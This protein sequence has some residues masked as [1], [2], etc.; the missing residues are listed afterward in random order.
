MMA[1][2]YDY[3]YGGS[4]HPETPPVM[5]NFAPVCN[6][7]PQAQSPASL[8]TTDIQGEEYAAR[9]ASRADE[10][11]AIAAEHAADEKRRQHNQDV[12][13]D[14]KLRIAAREDDDTR[15]KNSRARD[16]K[17]CLTR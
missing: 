13:N 2:G 8:P 11:A 1:R 16:D 17:Q 14:R 10:V 3:G 7:I 5:M 9:A 4:N 15:N 6:P 12:E